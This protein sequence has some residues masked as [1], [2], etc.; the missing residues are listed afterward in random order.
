[1]TVAYSR[2]SPPQGY[3]SNRSNRWP[4]IR[5][6]YWN[7]LRAASEAAEVYPQVLVSAASRT[8]ERPAPTPSDVGKEGQRP[9]PPA[10]HVPS[11]ISR[12]APLSGASLAR[13]A[14]PLL[15]SFGST[16]R[17]K[18]ALN[19]PPERQGR[20]RYP[21]ALPRQP[22]ATYALYPATINAKVTDRISS[23][24]TPPAECVSWSSSNRSVRTNRAA[25][26]TT[27]AMPTRMR[28]NPS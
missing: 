5:R 2:L 25:A 17:T 21:V 27:R 1:M 15:R 18:D 6:R 3:A 4:P 26:T 23:A 16:R 10:G 11:G 20:S 24:R 12:I 22:S 13:L 14:A 19:P 28:T 7:S 9:P 8:V